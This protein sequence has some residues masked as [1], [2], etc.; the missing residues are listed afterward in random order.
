MNNVI[1]E[2]NRFFSYIHTTVVSFQVKTTTLH[3]LQTVVFSATL[4]CESL[5]HSIHT[6]SIRH[7]AYL[8]FL[9][10]G[11]TYFYYR[12]LLKLV[13]HNNT[14]FV[15]FT[16]AFQVVLSWSLLFF[17]SSPEDA[18]RS[19]PKRRRQLSLISK[20]TNTVT[21]INFIRREFS[22]CQ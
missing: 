10:V 18:N 11:C 20:T 16:F 12:V 19:S 22:N 7:E 5:A 2:K 9:L 1:G 13:S 8:L 3:I 15:C 4:L 17:K 14:L 6:P 21:A